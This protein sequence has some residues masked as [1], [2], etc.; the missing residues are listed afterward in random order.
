MRQRWDAVGEGIAMLKI[1]VL[2]IAEV[3]GGSNV[4]SDG[5]TRLAGRT[6]SQSKGGE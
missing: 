1:V 3:E 5:P 4:G 2:G 6:A